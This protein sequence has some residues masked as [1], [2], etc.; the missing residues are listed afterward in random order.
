MGNRGMELTSKAWEKRSVG[1][2][3][4]EVRVI[5]NQKKRVQRPASELRRFA[6]SPEP[7]TGPV[8]IG[9]VA[10]S[11]SAYRPRPSLI[12]QLR[13][14]GGFRQRL[15]RRPLDGH[16]VSVFARPGADRSL[17]AGGRSVGTRRG[18]RIFD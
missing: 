10:P 13:S 16:R 1:F 4:R 12:L 7:P 6:G 11:R 14:L 2:K 15:M 5:A 18:G 8:Q 3:T 9:L 17:S